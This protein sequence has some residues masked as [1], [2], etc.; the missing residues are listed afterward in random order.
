MHSISICL[1]RRPT[2]QIIDLHRREFFAESSD[3]GM[4]CGHFYR[5]YIQILKKLTWPNMHVKIPK[6]SEHHL[7]DIENSFCF[8]GMLLIFFWTRLYG[9]KE[10][11]I[12]FE[13]RSKSRIRGFLFANRIRFLREIHQSVLHKI[14]H[15]TRYVARKTGQRKQSYKHFCQFVFSQNTSVLIWSVYTQ[16]SH[17]NLCY[18]VAHLCLWIFCALIQSG[19]SVPSYPTTVWVDFQSGW[20]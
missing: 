20:M 17:T 2:E 10:V 4:N 1:S 14:T 11:C 9:W 7:N 6:Y 8:Y 16:P 15:R 19:R 18:I 13:F 12:M 5:V 3:F